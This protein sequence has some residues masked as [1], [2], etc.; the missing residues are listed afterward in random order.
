MLACDPGVA[1][2]RGLQAPCDLEVN[3]KQIRSLS[4]WQVAHIVLYMHY[5]V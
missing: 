4:L 2:L 5:G 1:Q 3:F